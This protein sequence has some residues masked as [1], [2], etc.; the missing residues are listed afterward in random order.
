MTG[1]AEWLASLC[2]EIEHLLAAQNA[3]GMGHPHDPVSEGLSEEQA[4]RIDE[5]RDRGAALAAQF[6]DVVFL[7]QRIGASAEFN[8]AWLCGRVRSLLTSREHLHRERTRLNLE[9]AVTSSD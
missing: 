9:L 4:R 3:E 8:A 7:A 1:R 5:L 6:C 2:N